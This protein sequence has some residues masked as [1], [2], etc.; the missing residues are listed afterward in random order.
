MRKVMD[1]EEFKATR[2]EVHN[3]IGRNLGVDEDIYGL[4]EVVLGIAY[5]PITDKASVYV[6]G[7]NRSGR[8]S[9][10]IGNWSQEGELESVERSAYAAYLDG[11]FGGVVPPQLA[12]A[13]PPNKYDATE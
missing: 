12:S 7:P 11:E 3:L 5:G 2:R 9:I 13:K 8:F 6:Q 10:E 1:F 4:G